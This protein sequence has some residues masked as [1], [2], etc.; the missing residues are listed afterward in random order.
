MGSTFVC[1]ILDCFH[2]FLCAFV[3]FWVFL[4]TSKV[5]AYA[6]SLSFDR[7]IQ[8]FRAK[9][10][11]RTMKSLTS[12]KWCQGIKPEWLF[13]CAGWYWCTLFV[14]LSKLMSSRWSRHSIL[15][16][17][18]G[19]K[20]LCFT[21]QLERGGGIPKVAHVFLELTLDVWEWEI[22]VFLAYQSWPQ[23]FL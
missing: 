23:V 19:Q 15:V 22:W 6:N 11:L 7:T 9:P 12:T 14:L 4:Q 21:S 10:S 18:R 16:I 2:S 20:K 5:V 1:K 17:K 8:L 13:P 3:I